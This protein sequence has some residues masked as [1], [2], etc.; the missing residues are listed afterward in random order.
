MKEIAEGGR[1]GLLA[2]PWEAELLARPISG[3][4]KDPAERMRLVEV[5]GTGSGLV[6]GFGEKVGEKV[7]E[8]VGS[9]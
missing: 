1:A 5:A 2:K 9:G 4:L 7:G 6:M 8:G 3:L